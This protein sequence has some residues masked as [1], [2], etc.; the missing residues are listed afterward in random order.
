MEKPVAVRFARD[1]VAQ[2]NLGGGDGLP[3]EPFSTQSPVE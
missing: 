3:G 2:P 1:Q